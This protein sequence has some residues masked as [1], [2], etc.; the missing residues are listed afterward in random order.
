M[1]ILIEHLEFALTVDASDTVI[2]DAAL[3][4]DDDRIVDI[5]STADV[6]GRHGRSEHEQV[7]DGSRRGITP[8]FIDSHVHLSETLSRAVF[9]MTSIPVHGFFCGPSRSMPM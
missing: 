9:R 2:R 5:G 7:I 3:V 6:L 1:S 4:I 8:G